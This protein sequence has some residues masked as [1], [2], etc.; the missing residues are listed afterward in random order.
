[1]SV[2]SFISEFCVEEL[3]SPAQSPD[4]NPIQQLVDELKP[5]S[6]PGSQA[7]SSNIIV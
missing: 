7:L 6:E 2:K 3:H 4:L 5:D 1:M